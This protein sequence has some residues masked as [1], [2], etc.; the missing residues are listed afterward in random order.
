MT[1]FM[2]VPLRAIELARVRTTLPLGQT[3]V[4][5]RVVVVDLRGVAFRGATVVIETP[6][7]LLGKT[8][9]NGMASFDG[10]QI[11]A[12]LQRNNGK[13]AVPVRVM[14]GDLEIT[15]DGP[16]DETL[17]I[18]VPLCAPQPFLTTSELITLA[19]GGALVG[20]GMHLK[21]SPLQVVGEVLFGA[22]VFTAVYRH[23]CST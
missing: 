22:A 3:R 16:L 19:L 4:P 2:P 1:P 6:D 12:Q 14:I 7:A 11:E 23:S 13:K 5:F 17:F 18:Q 8:D 15:R 20:A 9:S 21:A 10:T